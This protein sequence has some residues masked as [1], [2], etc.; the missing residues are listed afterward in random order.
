MT[1]V[2]R[3]VV[4]LGFFCLLAAIPAS[5]DPIVITSGFLTAA[6][7]YGPGAT[8]S[9][10][11]TRGFSIE[12]RPTI[13]EGRIDPFTEC[14][15]CLPGTRISVG[16]LLSGSALPTSA[17][18][19][20]VTHTDINGLNSVQTIFLE[21]FGRAVVPPIDDT[22]SMVSVP[23]DLRGAFYFFDESR[24]VPI[25]GSGV[26]TVLF[27]TQPVAPGSAPEWM[28][29]GVRYDFRAAPAAVPEPATLAMVGG[30]I[31]AIASAVRRRRR[32]SPGR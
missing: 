22:T 11:G 6:S 29:G 8:I 15:P 28:V 4:S 7:A 19:D 2:V 10:Q 32:H 27:R 31:A 18:L 23:F 12:G 14:F 26:V 24:S 1:R 17:T 3:S 9:L 16:G 25:V 13:G 5:A 20:G 21:F 30:G